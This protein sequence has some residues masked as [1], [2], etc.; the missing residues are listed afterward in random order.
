MMLFT[1][2]ATTQVDSKPPV[3]IVDAYAESWVA[4]VRG[5]GSGTNVFVTVSEAM[6]LDSLYFR[7][8]TA[9]L[10]PLQLSKNHGY[11]ARFSNSA[12]SER[13]LVM[14]SDPKKE[15]GNTV[16]VERNS[17]TFPFQIKP[18]QAMVSY[19]KGKQIRYFL[20]E[21]ISTRKSKEF[22]SAPTP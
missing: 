22:P 5:G 10:R 1:Q 11:V 14:H 6:A 7:G 4:G 19:Q 12:N 16:A 8:K 17:N 20:I 21:N 13:D 2:C 15:Y 9:K 18:N 3:A